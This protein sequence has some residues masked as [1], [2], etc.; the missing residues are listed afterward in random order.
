MF[1]ENKSK[2]TEEKRWSKNR[3]EESPHPA[4]VNVFKSNITNDTSGLSDSDN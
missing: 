2:R 3:S 1:T 4:K